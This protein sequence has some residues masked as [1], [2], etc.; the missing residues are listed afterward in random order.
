MRAWRPIHHVGAGNHG[1]QGE[2]TGY[3]FCCG[4]NIRGNAEVIGGPHL[5]GAA[6]TALNLVEDQQDAVFLG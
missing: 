4:E 3:A 6:H 1:A 2:S 5:A